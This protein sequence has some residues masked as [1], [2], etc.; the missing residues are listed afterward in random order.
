MDDN[1]YKVLK[2]LV[3]ERTFAVLAGGFM[4]LS[5]GSVI[6]GFVYAVIVVSC[7]DQISVSWLA[8]LIALAAIVILLSVLY[9]VVRPTDTVIEYETPDTGTLESAKESL[10]SAFI[11]FSAGLF[12]IGIHQL[13]KGLNLIFTPFPII[14]KLVVPL[15]TGASIP[16]KELAESVGMNPLDVIVCLKRL[17]AVTFVRGKMRLNSKWYDALN[18]SACG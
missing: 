3:R 5:A 6:L 16:V 17:D 11:T 18:K 4:A 1:Q 8:H 15:K 9:M 12:F 14:Y 2:K 10:T 7:K 13:G